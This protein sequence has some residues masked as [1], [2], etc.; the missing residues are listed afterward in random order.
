MPPAKPSQPARLS[1]NSRSSNSSPRK[2]S[3]QSEG[4]RPAANSKQA[5]SSNVCAQQHHR[6]PIIPSQSTFS[7]TQKKKKKNPSSQSIVSLLTQ[8]ACKQ[9]ISRHQRQTDQSVNQSMSQKKKGH[10]GK[11]PNT[12]APARD[13]QKLQPRSIKPPN[14]TKPTKKACK[15]QTHTAWNA[16]GKQN[17]FKKLWPQVY[18]LGFR[19][20]LRNDSPMCNCCSHGTLLHVSPQGSHLSICYYHQDLCRWQLQAGS[21]PDPS[22]LTITPPYS[23]E[24][25]G[26]ATQKSASSVPAVEYRPN[27]KAPSIFRAGCFGR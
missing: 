16:R 18:E 23:L 19:L 4:N 10:R 27:A 17:A 7:S 5:Q 2:P 14:N 3:S 15:A 20:W 22:T 25:T 24:R 26:P 6:Q 13:S 12:N 21:H 11:K 8:P 9:G 1:K